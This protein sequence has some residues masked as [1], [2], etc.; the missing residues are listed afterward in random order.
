M[1]NFTN[2][3]P[4][5][6][7]RF[8]I[9]PTRMVWQSEG[10]SAPENSER[11]LNSEVTQSTVMHPGPHCI[12]RHNGQA[13]GLLV[14]FGRELHGGVQ[15]IVGETT[16]HKPVRLRVRLGESVSEAMAEPNQD[17]VINDAIVTV[18]W[19]GTAEIGS[20]GF[21]FAR[22]DT[23]DEGAYLEIMAF[24]AVHLIRDLE[25]KGSFE[26]ND[27]RLNRIWTTGA[28]TVHLN[29][30]DHLWDGIKRDRLVW[31]G[32]LHP[33]M[34]VISTVFGNNEI[35]PQSL[36]LARDEAP[37]P[38]FMNDHFSYSLWWIIIQ[39]DWYCHHGDRDNLEEQRDYLLALLE[40]LA[41]YD[42]ATLPEGFL[43]WPTSPNKDAVRAGMY[44]LMAMAFDAGAELCEVLGEA[45]DRE[46]CLIAAER[47]RGDALPHEQ[48][49]TVAALQALVGAIASEEA[50]TSVLAQAP[51]EGVSTFYGYYVLEARA[52][53]GD[54]Q[55]CLDVIRKYWG[56]MLDFGATTFWEDFDLS[57]TENA[58]RIDEIVPEGMKDLHVDYGDFCY[59]GLRHSL[60]HGWAGGPT[61]W[62]SEH[63]LGFRA[64]E[65]GCT[66]LEIAPHL[67]DLEWARGSFPTPYGIV[68]VT[69][70]RDAAGTVQ[71]EVNAPPAIEVIVRH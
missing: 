19:E 11:L 15:F 22:I 46:V 32:D 24:R 28:Y 55:G 54:Y 18:P 12:L 60:C 40:Q 52:K 34:K 53:A 7:T 35:L 58:G 68:K 1:I 45:A 49:K 16:D 8:Y 2:S 57:W 43:D 23:L 3:R 70:T 62:L 61:A 48:V 66:R 20:T 13:A 38:R 47:W 25:Y 6:R 9:S 30:Q 33:E 27:E 17:H 14:D 4:D 42:T 31:V 29:M 21:R 71:T 44:A 67:A 41:G 56:A 10:A 63:V 39:R 50:N 37:L 64:L 5:P 36:N 65:P 59:K 26:C 51:L 69:H